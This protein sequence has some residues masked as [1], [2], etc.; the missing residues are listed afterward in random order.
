[1]RAYD[2]HMTERDC[3]ISGVLTGLHSFVPCQ[4]WPTSCA[5]GSV[6]SFWDL[7]APTQVVLATLHGKP[8]DAD[9]I[10]LQR[11]TQLRIPF[12]TTSVQNHYRILAEPHT[13]YGIYAAGMPTDTC[14]GLLQGCWP[15]D[16]ERTDVYT[17]ICV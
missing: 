17:E 14:E 15:K 11:Y 1:M 2:L 12:G 7:G 8:G 9:S 4:A 16:R 13:G 3:E 10:Q 5:V 6:G